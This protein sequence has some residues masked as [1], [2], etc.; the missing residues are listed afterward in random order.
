[1]K[2]K[3]LEITKEET[4]RK[5]SVEEE[6]TIARQKCGGG[7]WVARSAAG[8]IRV[9]HTCAMSA[10]LPATALGHHAHRV[11]VW[12]LVVVH[13]CA[14]A[15]TILLTVTNMRL[16][17]AVNVHGVAS[18]LRAARFRSSFTTAL[19]HARAEVNAHARSVLLLRAPLDLGLMTAGA[20]R[21]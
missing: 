11:I 1:M 16:L 14:A 20:R 21:V 8:L 3:I 18:A 12:H 10:L 2:Y 17:I 9:M 6:R 19:R 15:L 13:S 4:Q 7:K 5:A